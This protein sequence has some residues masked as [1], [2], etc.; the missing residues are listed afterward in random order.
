MTPNTTRKAPINSLVLIPVQ[1]T[2]E[3]VGQQA[4]HI[5]ASDFANNAQGGV[6]TTVEEFRASDDIPT[7]RSVVTT[8]HGGGTWYYAGLD[9]GIYDDTTGTVVITADNHVWKRIFTGDL[10]ITWFGAVGDGVKDNLEVLNTVIQLSLISRTNIYIPEGRFKCN[11]PLIVPG[12]PAAS[13]IL[14]KGAGAR[15]SIL[16]FTD[17]TGSICVQYGTP[18][19]NTI[20]GGISDIQIQGTQDAHGLVISSHAPY[21]AAFNTFSNIYFFKVK[22]GITFDGLP[23]NTS[24][25]YQNFFYNMMVEEHWGRGIY[26]DGAMNIFD[27]GFIVAPYG[28]H[29]IPAVGVGANSCAVYDYGG[30]NT[31]NN[32]PS[33]DQWLLNGSNTKITRCTI[34]LIQKSVANSS[35]GD[36]AFRIGGS[37]VSIDGFTITTI[38][39]SIIN[40]MAY[41]YSPGVSLKNVVYLNPG[42]IAQYVITYPVLP[43]AGSNGIM[44]NVSCPTIYGINHPALYGGSDDWSFINVLGQGGVNFSRIVD[45]EFP[46][47]SVFLNKT[48]GGTVT[49]YTNF[50]DMNILSSLELH[51]IVYDLSGGWFI[52]NL[53]G[54]NYLPT[55]S[56][57]A[58]GS[59][60]TLNINNVGILNPD[61]LPITANGFFNSHGIGINNGAGTQSVAKI[62]NNGIDG[63]NGGPTLQYKS[64][65]V[66]I[67]GIILDRFG[68]TT[69]K[70]LL[71][72]KYQLSDLNSAPSS[73][74]DTGI[75][76][77]LRVVA[78][79]I[80]VCI[81][82]NT[83][84]R[85][86]L[87]TW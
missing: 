69:V 26:C 9:D 39:N 50:T 85:A 15:N 78:D 28:T 76:G 59:E 8:D 70:G 75:K 6:V 47:T 73:A 44:E 7:N 66:N 12:R 60:A 64:A 23:S 38:P 52:R 11:G 30:G 42:D 43:S 5:S 48:T 84:V 45:L 10:D 2:N 33:E 86:P 81:A 36:C 80:Y 3:P 46:D 16:D 58:T 57:N 87:A 62:I 54:D 79:Y 19:T 71:A 41:I 22:D 61:G 14:I 67:D 49:G 17:S 68:N 18:D 65:G 74:T 53:A 56:R 40:A 21:S 77:E 1:D 82:T 35:I 34:E 32:I 83:W 13:S 27:G 20:H 25:N 4:K 55:F 63:N 72:D 24:S 51:G 31:Y 37:G 29:G